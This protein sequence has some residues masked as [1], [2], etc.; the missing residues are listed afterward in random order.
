MW[1]LVPL[2]TPPSIS[3][4]VEDPTV[5]FR[6]NQIGWLNYLSSKK[7]CNS[8]NMCH[9]SEIWKRPH[10]CEQLFFCLIVSLIL[11]FL[12]KIWLLRLFTAHDGKPAV[13]NTSSSSSSLPSNYFYLCNSFQHKNLNLHILTLCFSLVAMGYCRNMGPNPNDMI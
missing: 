11:Q 7:I 12:F 6:S 8:E 3:R 9:L 5:D 10:E 1:D 13:A 4:R 2:K